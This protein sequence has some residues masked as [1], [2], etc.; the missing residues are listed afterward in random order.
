VMIG[1][2]RFNTEG[3]WRTR[4]VIFSARANPTPSSTA[5]LCA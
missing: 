1:T 4:P 2:G 3:S 5:R